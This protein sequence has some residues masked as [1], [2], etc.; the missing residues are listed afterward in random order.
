MGVVIH[1]LVR[2]DFGERERRFD[3]SLGLGAQPRLH[4]VRFAPE[5]AA[6]VVVKRAATGDREG[7]RQDRLMDSHGAGCPLLLFFT[8]CR[9]VALP[10]DRGPTPPVREWQKEP[11]IAKIAEDR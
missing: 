10:D 9:G 1:E 5:V 8:D 2:V 6:Q 11:S 4:L 3:E 7:Q